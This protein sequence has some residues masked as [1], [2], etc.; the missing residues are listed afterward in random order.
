MAQS[1]RTPANRRAVLVALEHG[2]TYKAAA[3]SIGCSYEW[4]RSWCADDSAFSAD[5]EKAKARFVLRNLRVIR[6]AALAGTWQAAAWGLERTDPEHY[7][8]V[9][10]EQRHTGPEGGPILITQVEVIPP[11]AAEPLPDDD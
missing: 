2:A 9:V 5:V 6:K 11:Y 1:L 3:N 7:G 8:R 10:Q 4:F